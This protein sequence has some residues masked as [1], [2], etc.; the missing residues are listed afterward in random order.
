MLLSEIQ[1]KDIIN[2]D[3]GE[4]LGYINDLEIDVQVG[5]IVALIVT[6][7][8]K[9]FGIFGEEEEIRILWSQIEKIGADVIL[10]RTS[11]SKV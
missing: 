10:V 6:L 5:S 11:Y 4:K 3:S 7:K 9:W 2:V 1:I 8:S